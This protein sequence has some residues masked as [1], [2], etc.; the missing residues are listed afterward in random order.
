MHIPVTKIW[1]QIVNDVCY[2]IVSHFIKYLHYT[3]LS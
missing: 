1:N 3:F 2:Y